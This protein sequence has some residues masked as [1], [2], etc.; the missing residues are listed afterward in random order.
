METKINRFLD[1]DAVHWH[2]L[3]QGLPGYETPEIVEAVQKSNL[4]ADL[5][6]DNPDM[7]STRADG[8]DI[9]VAIGTKLKGFVLAQHQA[10]CEQPHAKEMINAAL[11]SDPS[12][13]LEC[14][15][16]YPETFEKLRKMLGY[17]RDWRVRKRFDEVD[18]ITEPVRRFREA[19]A[20]IMN[21]PNL[22]R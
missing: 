22:S 16:V 2:R 20:G 8:P 12:Q 21:D 1:G 19:L 6:F 3:V 17:T 15:I 10:A 9:A 18:K 7:Y 4:F 13:G 5:L 14:A 11:Q